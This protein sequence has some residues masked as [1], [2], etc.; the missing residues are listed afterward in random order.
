M[1]VILILWL[2]TINWIQY[3]YTL[4]RKNNYER[5]RGSE[6]TKNDENKIK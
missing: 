1:F 5:K 4:K 3:F 6:S 2:I